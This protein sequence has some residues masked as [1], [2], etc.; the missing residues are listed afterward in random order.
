MKKENSVKYLIGIDEVGR[1]P[2]AGPV[3]VGV[4]AIEKAKARKIFAKFSVLRDSKKMTAKNREE[5]FNEVLETAEIFFEIKK[6]SAKE[7]DKIGISKCIKK[8]ISDGLKS[9]E[10]KGIDG[11]N[12]EVRLDGALRAPST[13][14][15][16][17]TI[18]RGDDSE[19]IISLASILAKVYRDNLMTKLHK[20]FPKYNF[21][22]NKGYGTK[23]HVQA[24]K[25]HGQSSEH[26]KSFCTRI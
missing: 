12:S 20:K 17:K 1:G 3:C 18:I 9:L 22:Q 2:L 5:I 6:C 16:Q 4:V 7:I 21:T 23:A 26:R 14:P 10:K 13:Y 15:N 8:C 19:K 25:K 11:G 24:I